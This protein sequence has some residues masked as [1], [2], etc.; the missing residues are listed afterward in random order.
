[1]GAGDGFLSSS[2]PALWIGVGAAAALEDV[3]VRWPDGRVD[4]V[5]D[6]PAGHALMVA[7]GGEPGPARP[8][9]D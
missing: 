6:V 2:D 8:M 9:G 3:R 1:M 7:A 4:E 5:G